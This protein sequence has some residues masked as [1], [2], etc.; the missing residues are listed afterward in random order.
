MQKLL[1]VAVER[2]EDKRAKKIH[3]RAAE[4][5]LPVF[6]AN[7]NDWRLTTAE[8]LA[9]RVEANG[10]NSPEVQGFLAQ[11]NAVI[12]EG[13]LLYPRLYRRD[14][15]VSSA[16][17]WPA[18]AVRDFARMGFVL[19][20]QNSY[21]AIFSTREPLDFPQGADAIL[22]GC[23]RQ[24]YIEARLVVFPTLPASYLSAPLSEGCD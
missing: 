5:S 23:Q 24:D 3:A 22:L 21:N 12:L 13:R 1:P 2:R 19:L 7:G 20:N 15:G 16:H 4:A 8:Q 9:A 17:P 14:Q 10:L 11:P 6:K 18:Y